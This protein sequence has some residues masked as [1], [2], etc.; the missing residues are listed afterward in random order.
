MPSIPRPASTDHSPGF[1]AEISLVPD[2][3][4]FGAML[5]DQL[6]A[7]RTL[8]ARFGEKHAALRY[9]PDKW[10]VRE[11]VGHL[12]DCERVLSY[13]ALRILR[14]DATTLPGFDHN[15]YVPAGAFEARS[16]VAVLEEFSAVRAATVSLVAGAPADAW[17]RRTV[18]GTTPTTAAA[19]LYLIA[20]HERH[21]QAQ[22]RERYLPCLAKPN[23]MT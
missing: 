17:T 19:L 7:T 11:I 21:H 8:L 23:G 4:D 6:I 13:R 15:G 16:L 20:G 12:A 18:I 9:A 1:L 2:V 14:G 3:D 10:T 22:L 5:V